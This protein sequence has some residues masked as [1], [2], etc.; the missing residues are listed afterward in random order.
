MILLQNLFEKIQIG[1]E[2][3]TGRLLPFFVF[4]RPE[5]SILLADV[6][7]SDRQID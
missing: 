2:A 4:S 3:I 5:H 6:L 7:I 1:K